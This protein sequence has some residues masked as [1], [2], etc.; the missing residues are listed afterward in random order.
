MIAERRYGAIKSVYY[1]TAF[2]TN[3]WYLLCS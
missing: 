3:E 2:V 1:F